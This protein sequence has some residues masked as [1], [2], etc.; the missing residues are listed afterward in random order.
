MRLRA[1]CIVAAPTDPYVARH[2]TV[3]HLCCIAPV[4]I[5]VHAPH[6]PYG[7]YDTRYTRRSTWLSYVRSEGAR[8]ESERFVNMLLNDATYLLDECLAKLRAI[9]DAEA[10]Q[11]DAAAWAA[12]PQQVSKG[13]S[14]G[15][16]GRV[17]V[18]G[19]GEARGSVLHSGTVRCCKPAG[20]VV[21]VN[22][23]AEVVLGGRAVA[24]CGSGDQH[25]TVPPFLAL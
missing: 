21:W 3:L 11:A 22:G 1:R 18:A 16:R 8:G 7:T 6:P 4:S 2:D 23:G 24:A 15:G 10:R 25:G 5:L 9:R 14:R 17:S 13:H 20:W 19:G 12:T